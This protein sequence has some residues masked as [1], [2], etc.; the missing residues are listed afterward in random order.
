MF[1]LLEIFN[2]SDNTAQIVRQIGMKIWHTIYSLTDFTIPEF[3]ALTKANN[4]H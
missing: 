3:A 4:K 2:V 1:F